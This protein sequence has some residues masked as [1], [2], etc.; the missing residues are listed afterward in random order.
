L[1]EKLKLEAILVSERYGDV[2]GTVGR[3]GLSGTVCALS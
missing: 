2:E 3:V 1:E